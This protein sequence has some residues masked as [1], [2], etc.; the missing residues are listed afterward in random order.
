MSSKTTKTASAKSAPANLRNPA[1]LDWRKHADDFLWMRETIESIV[2]A[3][4][5]AFLFRTFEAEP[6]VIPTGSMAPTLLDDL[7]AQGNLILT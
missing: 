1:A 3:F 7:I 6:F 4:L 5:L 2:V